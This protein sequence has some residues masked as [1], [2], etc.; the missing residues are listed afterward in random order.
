M[1]FG[2][3]LTKPTNKVGD[4]LCP[5]WVELD[6]VKLDDYNMQK[7]AKAD[8]EDRKRCYDTTYGQ[9]GKVKILWCT[10][11]EIIQLEEL[12]K[13]HDYD[14]NLEKLFT[15]VPEMTKRWNKHRI[16][17]KLKQ[18]VKEQVWDKI[19]KILKRQSDSIRNPNES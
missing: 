11:F 17:I 19:H 7:S 5:Y 16:S 14:Y 10:D 8:N 2:L 18:V 13:K 1:V 12:Y 15:A 4:D 3:K 6:P 9:E